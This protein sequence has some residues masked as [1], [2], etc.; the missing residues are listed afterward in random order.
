MIMPLP[1]V[2]WAWATGFVG[3]VG[4][5]EGLRFEDEPRPTLKKPQPN[6]DRPLG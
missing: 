4:E 2:S 3:D 1:K 6:N 5:P